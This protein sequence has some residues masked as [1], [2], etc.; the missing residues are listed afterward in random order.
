MEVY[1]DEEKQANY[2]FLQSAIQH[3]QQGKRIT[4][5]WMEEQKEMILIYRDFWPDM[6]C[7]NPDIR[8]F[9]F[10]AQAVEAETLLTLLY[11]EICETNT[12]SVD[13][14]HVF[15]MCVDK[16]ADTFCEDEDVSNMFASFTLS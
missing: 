14:Y 11:E 6:T 16:M 3:V 4:E 13:T 12:F 15:N 2:M 1:N 7:L 10:R 5:D 8:D 9:R